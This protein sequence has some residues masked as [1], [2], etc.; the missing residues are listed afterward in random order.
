[1][2]KYISELKINS[3]YDQTAKT[4]ENTKNECD[5]PLGYNYKIE[6]LII[7]CSGPFSGE[8]VSTQAQLLAGECKQLAAT[9][10]IAIYKSFQELSL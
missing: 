6:F 2:I 1:M 5:F 3:S 7:R 8:T 4:P 10:C 9:T